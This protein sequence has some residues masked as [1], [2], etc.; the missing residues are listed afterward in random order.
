MTFFTNEIRVLQYQ[1]KKCV[2]YKEDYDE[3]I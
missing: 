3:S 2:D 1:S